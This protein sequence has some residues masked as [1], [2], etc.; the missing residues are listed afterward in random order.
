MYNELAQFESADYYYSEAVNLMS[1]V[2][3]ENYR[4]A[5]T[6]KAIIWVKVPSRLW[7][8]LSL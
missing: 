7:K 2:K 1:G 5:V 4:D 8:P 3:D 6:F